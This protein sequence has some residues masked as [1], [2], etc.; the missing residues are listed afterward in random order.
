MPRV[1]AVRADRLIS[2]TIYSDLEGIK[3]YQANA[4][5]NAG[6]VVITVALST[7]GTHNL[8]IFVE[9]SPT[10]TWSPLMY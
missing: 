5:F 3:V 2:V 7:V 10:P 8:R 6:E 1:K 4:E 9:G